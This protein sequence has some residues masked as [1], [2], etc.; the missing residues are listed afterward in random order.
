MR[1]QKINTQLSSFDLFSLFKDE[2]YSFFLDSGRDHMGMGRYSYIGCNPFLLFKS[3]NNRVTL[4]QD[5]KTKEYN[6]DPFIILKELI[7][8]YSLD[9]ESEIPFIGGAVG[10]FSYDLCHHIEYLPR[11][12]CD[13]VQIPDCHLGFYD[14]IVIVDHLN[15]ECFVA[16]LGV[17]ESEQDIINRL[18]QR[19][20]TGDVLNI[21]FSET[22]NE[23]LEFTSNF[24]KKE[25]MNALDSIHNYIE[26][27]DIYQTNLSQRIKCKLQMKPIELYYHL[28][29]INPAPFAS[30]I[31]F[32]E[33]QIVS[34]SPERFIKVDGNKIETRPIKGTIPRGKT[35]YEDDFNRNQLINSSKD[36]AELLMIVDLERN[37]LGK[38]SKPGTV[39]V[40]ELYKLEEYETVFHL[41]STVT[42]ELRDNVDPIDCITATFPGGSI[43][44]APKIRAMEIIDEL[45]PNQRNIYTGSIGYI[46]FNN[47]MD[48]NI[49]IRTILC[50]DNYAYFGVGG[51]IVWDS[52][53]QLEYEETFHK[54][55]ALMDALRRT[56]E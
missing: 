53:N 44:G 46:G 34:S 38:I 14:G 4:V 8:E 56:Y 37:D 3:K 7:N 15:E 5:G 27:G 29:T 51:G 50:K 26:E 1:I 28:R 10:F 49:V 45:E 47:D 40:P 36:K 41:V 33:G 31:D 35:K 43:T 12:A 9:Y 2:S 54:G 55:K 23:D 21:K 25:Y 11:N 18:I 6:G 16:A 13:D 48:L 32:G 52:Q 19:I 42:G 17:K 20:K 39:K 30:Y 24:T 22:I